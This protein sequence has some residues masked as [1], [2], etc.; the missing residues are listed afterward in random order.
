M[1]KY[2]RQC[3]KTSKKFKFLNFVFSYQN[4]HGEDPQKQSIQDHRDVFPIL[5]NLKA[6][7]L[8]FNNSQSVV[9][10]PL[11]R[12]LAGKRGER[13]DDRKMIK[14]SVCRRRHVDSAFASFQIEYIFK[15]HLPTTLRYVL[16]SKLQGIKIVINFC[17]NLIQPNMKSQLEN[18]RV[19]EAL[20]TSP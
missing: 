4:C 16:K 6:S 18:A 7:F 8:H 9:S 10:F 3:Q 11:R 1:L 13:I 19:N 12:T 14:H 2:D 5:A 17:Y 20:E 15:A